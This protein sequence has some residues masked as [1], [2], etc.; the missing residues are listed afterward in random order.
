VITVSPTLGSL[1]V[2]RLISF[3]IEQ[4]TSN[5]PGIKEI[6]SISRFGL[7]VVSIVFDDD[8]D[9]YWCR[10]QV[11][12]RMTMIR[13]E[14][15][16][17]AGSPE[18]APVTT[19]LGEIYQYVVK[20]K[21]GYEQQYDL[22]E[23]RTIQDWIIRRQLM[24]TPGVADVSSFGGKLKQ[25][26]VAIDPAKMKSLGITL[27]QVF[28][29]LE[30]NNQ[31]SGAAYIEKG[32]SLL[33]IRTEGLAK[34]IE[35][36]NSIFLS[37]SAAGTPVFISDVAEV[38][39]GSP[40]RYGAL[41][42]EDQGEVSGA[43][44][45]MLKGE[46]ASQVIAGIEKR[47]KQIEKTLP[48]GVEVKTF[49]NRTKMVNR[50][51]NTVKTNLLEGALIVKGLQRLSSTDMNAT[52]EKAAA[53]M[54]NA[55]VFGQVIILI[56]YIPILS[57][58]GIEGKMFKPMA[59]TVAFALVGAFILSLTY[60]PMVTSLG[61]SKKMPEK[62]NFSNR[63]MNALQVRFKNLLTKFLLHPAKV[64]I[65]SLSLFV[66]SILVATRLG[67]EFIPELEEGD[68]AID[69]R[70]M[71]GSSL[72]ETINATTKA[73]TELKKFPEVKS[74]VTRIGASE[75]PT[76]PMPIEMTDIIVNLKDKSEWTSA[77]SYDELANKMSAAKNIWR[78]S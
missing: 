36:I 2:E 20:A 47:M 61:L 3:P 44:V 76:D 74:V 66:I 49:L 41:T 75:I 12:E 34:N 38:K 58:T 7:S 53:K 15:P 56:V 45:L 17:E 4:A 77:E 67:G 6:R 32:P 26:E 25:Y 29:A 55:A 42:Y 63:M 30:K 19:G 14:I 52:V 71:T 22:T 68:F 39:I 9:V 27:D 28:N 48:E 40:I 72:Q 54:M 21:K 35:E 33:F 13:D 59:Q 24:G 57:L 78:K 60:V 43:V 1:E 23:L 18:L 69:A 31:N 65:V 10:Q 11:S 16:K 51:L 64:V 8:K 46:N 62:E 5:I 73:V 50:T 70:L 37:K